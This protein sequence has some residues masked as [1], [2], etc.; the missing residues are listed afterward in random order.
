MKERCRNCVCLI[1]DDDQD[2]YCD[3]MQIKCILIDE[4]P[5][6]LDYDKEEE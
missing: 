6:A 5:Y 3:E 2:W 4:C 1:E